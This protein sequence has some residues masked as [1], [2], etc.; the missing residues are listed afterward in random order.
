M[1]SDQLTLYQ[2]VQDPIESIE[3]V[4]KFISE[5]KLVPVPNAA[6]GAMVA[7]WCHDTGCTPLDYA[8]TYHTI[9]GKMVMKAHAM[10]VEFRRRGGRQRIAEY[11]S[12]RCEME[13]EFEGQ[14][15]TF[16]LSWEDAQESRWPWKDPNDHSKG[17]KANWSTPMD[18]KRMLHA[19]LISMACIVMCPEINYGISTVEEAMDGDML[20]AEGPI[21]VDFT[22]GRR[23]IDMSE[24]MTKRAE[25]I[26][27]DIEAKD[28]PVEEAPFE[29]VKLANDVQI[30]RIEQLVKRLELT[31][32][33]IEKMLAKRNVNEVELLTP[34]QADEL[35]E[36]LEEFL[37]KKS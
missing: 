2:K 25:E 20:T 29:E 13:L 21:D 7:W 16:A 9:D 22:G 8:R 17:L 24:D 34:D 36:R 11:S 26:A 32:E 6:A 28:A 18:R 4:G 31:D 35:I 33:Q 27:A 19:R 23:V 12:E 14:T 3:R 37:R 10:M 1:T 5:S 30:G 15:S